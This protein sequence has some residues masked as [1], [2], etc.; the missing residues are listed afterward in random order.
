[1]LSVLVRQALGRQRLRHRLGARAGGAS[2]TRDRQMRKLATYSMTLTLLVSL[3]L[4][5][6][7]FLPMLPPP[8]GLLLLVPWVLFLVIKPLRV[9]IPQLWRSLSTRSGDRRRWHDAPPQPRPAA[10]AWTWSPC[11]TWRHALHAHGERY[12]QRIFTPH[13]LDCCRTPERL[14]DRLAGRP[15]RRQGGDDQGA[16]A[17]G[18]PARLELHGGAAAA[19]DGSCAMV[20]VRARP[21]RWPRRPGSPRS[22]LSMTHEGD[23]AA[24]VVFALCGSPPETALE[25]SRR[26]DAGTARVRSINARQPRKERDADA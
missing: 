9:Q 14:V 22:S 25:P 23:Y 2:S 4:A 18:L 20:A 3:I 6:S 24:A 19:A 10:S 17:G 16:P 8:L 13:E 12:L 1:M 21:P 5:P 11:A 15:L 7:M 26:P